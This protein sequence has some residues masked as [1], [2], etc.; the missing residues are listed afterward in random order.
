MHNHF[1]GTGT[2]HPQNKSNQI[3][4]KLDFIDFVSKE[5]FRLKII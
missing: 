4:P 5:F 3:S 2:K 1:H